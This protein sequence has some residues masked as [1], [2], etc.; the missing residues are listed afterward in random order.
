MARWRVTMTQDRPSSFRISR[1]RILGGF[2][3]S[4]V[5]V[6]LP[7]FGSAVAS[8]ATV[9]GG[10]Q[11]RRVVGY[12][13]V[14]DNTMGTNTVAGFARYGDGTL[15]PLP[16]SPFPVGGAGNGGA[17]PSQGA[18][19]VSSDKRYLLAVDA[20]SNQISVARI[21]SDGTLHSVSGS[22]FS[23]NGIKPV[24]VAIYRDLVYVANAGDGGSNYTG[25]TFQQN[26]RLMPLGGSTVS[27][28][29]GAGIGQVLFDAKGE[30]LVGIRVD[31]SLIDSFVVRRNGRLFTSPGSPFVAQAVGPFGSAFRA[32]TNP[33]QLLVS[34]AHEGAGK[35]SVSS[36]H[37]SDRGV[38]NA[39]GG[40]P[41]P[42]GQTA[43]CWVTLSPDGRYLFAA[44]TGSSSIS[45]YR[46]AA[47]GALSLV[48]STPLRGGSGLGIFDL[49]LDPTGR[50]LYQ[51][52]GG[53]QMIAVLRVNGG[54]L[55]E[56]P[57]SPIALPAN[58]SPW[59]IVVI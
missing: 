53:K 13:Y 40:S 45:G 4:V 1:R 9:S 5:A 6:G 3:A 18:L 55:S 30:H 34:N 54:S 57:S 56:L 52:E 27:V 22:P 36:F 44:N 15:A 21:S 58:S 42:N 17:L 20:G 59:G 14:N 11:D 24:S 38:L 25:F 31:T 26:G 29:D 19:A 23:S 39:L 43:T 33:A 47:N 35:G 32:G 51:L 2:A 49:G 46:I 12:L 41:F 16:G 50:Y 8:A 10:G 48:G 37:V 28:P 7:G